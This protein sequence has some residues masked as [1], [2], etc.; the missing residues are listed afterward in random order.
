MALIYRYEQKDASIFNEK[1]FLI[2][3]TC[4]E[5]LT[6]Y[7]GDIDEGKAKDLLHSIEIWVFICYVS[8]FDNNSV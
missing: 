4:Y 3:Y 7:K 6:R 5:I 8:S 2:L 1:S